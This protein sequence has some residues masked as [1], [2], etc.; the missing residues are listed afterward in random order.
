M[1]R[2]TP[3]DQVSEGGTRR[4][5]LQ[6]QPLLWN[7]V[8]ACLQHT[9]SYK[10]NGLSMELSWQNAYLAMTK[11]RVQ[12]PALYKQGVRACACNPSSWSLVATGKEIQGHPQLLSGFEVSL[13]H[14]RPC[15]KK[16][17]IPSAWKATA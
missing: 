1:W 13:R 3:L 14:T 12:S 6:E 8:A 4:S 11:T 2:P 17:K 7:E 9:R 15:L 16:G 10:A 5:G